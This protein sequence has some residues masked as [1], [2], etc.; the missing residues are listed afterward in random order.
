MAKSQV[1]S[2]EAFLQNLPSAEF[3]S[4]EA[5]G[6]CRAFVCSRLDRGV[7]FLFDRGYSSPKLWARIDHVGAMTQD[8][9]LRRPPTRHWITNDSFFDYLGLTG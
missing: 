6:D 7:L 5:F 1:G 3:I 8:P 9:E 4:A 2:P